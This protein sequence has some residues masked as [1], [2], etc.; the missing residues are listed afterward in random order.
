MFGLIKKPYK[1]NTL[2]QIDKMVLRN[3]HFIFVSTLFY[4]LNNISYCF[5]CIVGRYLKKSKLEKQ[6]KINIKK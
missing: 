3:I 5:N 6:F 2:E 4:L 1:N